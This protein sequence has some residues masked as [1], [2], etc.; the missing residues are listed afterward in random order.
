MLLRLSTVDM[1]CTQR[2]MIRQGSVRSDE[3]VCR[4][5]RVSSSLL[6]GAVGPPASLLI[7][8]LRLILLEVG[9]I[10]D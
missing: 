5:T 10:L 2:F 6:R 7:G 1:Y 8:E 4:M 3:A 9:M